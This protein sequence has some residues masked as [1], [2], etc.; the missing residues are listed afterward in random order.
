MIRPSYKVGNVKPIKISQALLETLSKN[1]NKITGRRLPIPKGDPKEVKQ[2]RPGLTLQNRKS[3]EK[4][5]LLTVPKDPK[6]KPDAEIFRENRPAAINAEPNPRNIPPRTFFDIYEGTPVRLSQSTTENLKMFLNQPIKLG[7]GLVYPFQ[8][9]LQTVGNDLGLICKTIVQLIALGDGIIPY[10]VLYTKGLFDNYVKVASRQF[11]PV[12]INY[13]LVRTLVENYLLQQNTPT[14]QQIQHLASCFQDI[15]MPPDPATNAILWET[16]NIIKGSDLS[17]DL[18]FYISHLAPSDRITYA[19]YPPGMG[20]FISQLLNAQPY[21][22]LRDAPFATCLQEM[23]RFPICV[24]DIANGNM[25]PAYFRLGEYYT[26]KQIPWPEK[27][28]LLINEEATRIQLTDQISAVAARSNA[29]EV[30]DI[31]SG[32]FGPGGP[33][34]PGGPGGPGPRFP[35]PGPQP[36]RDEQGYPTGPPRP[37]RGPPGGGGGP[38][39]RESTASSSRSGSSGFGG[40]GGRG[41]STAGMGIADAVATLSTSEPLAIAGSQPALIAQDEL[42]AEELKEREPGTTAGGPPS[43]AQGIASGDEPDLFSMPADEIQALM[44]ATGAFQSIDPGDYLQAL[45]EYAQTGSNWMVEEISRNT[46]YSP[47]FLMD[48]IAVYW[49]KSPLPS[50]DFKLP[51]NV[52]IPDNVDRNDPYAVINYMVSLAPKGVTPKVLYTEALKAQNNW[53]YLSPVI[54]KIEKINVT[55][56]I[57]AN[58]FKYVEGLELKRRIEAIKRLRGFSGRSKRAS[59]GRQPTGLSTGGPIR[60]PVG[61]PRGALPVPPPALTPGQAERKRSAL[62]A[63]ADAAERLRQARTLERARLRQQSHE[64]MRQQQQQQFSTPSG[65]VESAAGNDKE[66]QFR[67]FFEQKLRV[68]DAKLKA[69]EQ[70]IE[71]EWRKEDFDTTV[72]EQLEAEKTSL[73]SERNETI[74]KTRQ[75]VLSRKHE[76]NLKVTDEQYIKYINRQLNA[77]T[78][79]EVESSSIQSADIGFEVSTPAGLRGPVL[80]PQQRRRRQLRDQSRLLV[81]QQSE[82]RKRAFDNKAG[83]EKY[84]QDTTDVV[85]A[86]GISDNPQETLATE[87]RRSRFQISDPTPKRRRLDQTPPPSPF[88]ADVSGISGPLSPPGDRTIQFLG[89]AIGGAPSDLNASIAE[90]KQLTEDMSKLD[91]TDEANRIL[92]E[93]Q[94]TKT[95]IFNIVSELGEIESTMYLEVIGDADRKLEEAVDNWIKSPTTDNTLLKDAA[96]KQAMASRRAL[97]QRA[98][99]VA[100]QRARGFHIAVQQGNVLRIQQQRNVNQ[101]SAFSQVGVP[102]SSPAPGAAP[103]AALGPAP[104][105]SEGTTVLGVGPV[106]GRLQKFPGEHNFQYLE[107]PS[108]DPDTYARLSKWN[109]PRDYYNEPEMESAMKS[110]GIVTPT[111]LSSKK[112]PWIAQA[113]ENMLTQMTLK[114]S[115]TITDA[116]GVYYTVPQAIDLVHYGRGAKPGVPGETMYLYLPDMLIATPIEYQT[117]TGYPYYKR[118]WDDKNKLVYFTNNQGEH[119]PY[120]Y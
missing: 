34:P 53:D 91:N 42:K 52:D 93:I 9:L 95:I 7:P 13:R 33:P 40:G 10:H 18:S 11:D 31:M 60:E 119:I 29:F 80:T 24:W 120:T 5:V 6:Y 73:E 48:A 1:Y 84:I 109:I 69:V 23:L 94:K 115:R 78:P 71:Q 86:Q 98:Q 58:V 72:L 82:S 89:S 39:E 17:R 26:D 43:A 25:A 27:L 117:I 46:G 32:P 83:V 77:P 19:R 104:S 15:V 22:S 75:Q 3:I 59:S 112:D 111:A 20:V 64:M 79:M 110:M 21:Y 90:I 41:V 45:I 76:S 35:P 4:T 67:A 87:T 68:V 114:F 2:R 102:E 81:T 85:N 63:E 103:G 101:L 88:G 51:D 54:Q 14:A 116:Q 113:I 118:N 92:E 96:L 37:P 100:E 70:S 66:S 44:Q 28:S 56:T 50:E 65:P 16:S 38:S 55:P 99:Q 106:P 30:P 12:H 108:N 62:Q 36:P 61:A 49:T 107:K 105:E 47:E 74:R 8:Q 57:I 97:I